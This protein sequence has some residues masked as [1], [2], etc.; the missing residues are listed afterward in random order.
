M[1]G[2]ATLPGLAGKEWV[3]ADKVFYSFGTNPVV[4]PIDWTLG[5]SRKLARESGIPNQGEGCAVIA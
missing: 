5:W 4:K 1:Y 2:A 3:Q